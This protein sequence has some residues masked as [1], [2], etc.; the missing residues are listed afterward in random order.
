MEKNNTIYI[1]R[2]SFD[3]ISKE[4]IC[5]IENI[6]SQSDLNKLII[7]PSYN[8]ESIYPFK[9]R[10]NL[11]NKMYEKDT[12]VLVSGVEKPLKE[13]ES[14]D[15]NKGVIESICSFFGGI[16]K[17]ENFKLVLESYKIREYDKILKRPKNGLYSYFF[18]FNPSQFYFYKNVENY[19]KKNGIF[20]NSSF[21]EEL[22]IHQRIPKQSKNDF[23]ENIP[24]FILKEERGYSNIYLNHYREKENEDILEILL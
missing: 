12:R 3:P 6:L 23:E 7:I 9:G 17:N 18:L 22:D 14:F 2:D 16:H 13:I 10:L 19:C 21:L 15:E 8:S 11:L 4:K 5:I 1:Y 20:F 24:N